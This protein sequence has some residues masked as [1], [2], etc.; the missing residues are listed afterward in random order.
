MHVHTHAYTSACTH[1]QTDTHIYNQTLAT[2][3]NLYIIHIER[4]DTN[5][6]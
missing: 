2:H 1:T 3:L 6:A 4:I 5:Q